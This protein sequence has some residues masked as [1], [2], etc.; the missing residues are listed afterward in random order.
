[1]CPLV[2][3]NITTGPPNYTNILVINCRREELQKNHSSQIF[4]LSSRRNFWVTTL[5]S[6]PKS[7]DEDISALCDESFVS[8]DRWKG[9]ANQ[10]CGVKLLLLVWTQLWPLNTIVPAIHGMHC[11]Q[12]TRILESIS[13]ETS[14]CYAA[15]KPNTGNTEIHQRIQNDCLQANAKYFFSKQ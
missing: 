1:M 12:I 2:F 5:E 10:T 8:W 15:L 3:Y 11:N 6:W 7:G 14:A 13:T 4:L 9:E